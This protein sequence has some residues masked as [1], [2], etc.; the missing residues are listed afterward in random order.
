VFA[1]GLLVTAC[2][3]NVGDAA[4]PME[5]DVESPAPPASEE[6]IVESS[7]EPRRVTVVARD[8]EWDFGGIRS[9]PPG[10][11]TLAFVNEGGQDHDAFLW[12]LAEGVTFKR[13]RRALLSDPGGGYLPPP[14]L[15]L[16]DGG[17]G[18]IWEAPPGT[19]VEG[20]GVELEPGTYVLVCAQ[21]DQRVEQGEGRRKHHYEFGMLTPFEVTP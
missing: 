8:F 14:V 9:F 11:V 2:A 4:D 5:A 16:I 21:P 15:E 3:G 1:L 13:F 10:P 12:R 6:T 18:F 17:E 19:T 20:R 7:P